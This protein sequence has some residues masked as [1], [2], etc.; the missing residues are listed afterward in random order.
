MQ[1]QTINGSDRRE[2]VRKFSDKWNQED[3][4]NMLA[5]GV[6]VVSNAP[7][8]LEKQRQRFKSLYQ[9]SEGDNLVE[10]AQTHLENSSNILKAS[11]NQY[12]E[13][14]KV[15]K[16]KRSD[17]VFEPKTDDVF[18]EFAAHIQSS[19]ETWKSRKH[20]FGKAHKYAF[21]CCETLSNHSNFF[22]I[23]PTQNQYCALFC[24]V[25]KTLV[26]A[27]ANHIELGKRLDETIAS[28]NDQVKLCRL[29]HSLMQ[30]KDISAL[31]M[32]LYTQVFKL[33]N[34]ILRHFTSKLTRIFNAFNENS[35]TIKFGDQVREITNT[36]DRIRKRAELG[37]RAEIRDMNLAMRYSLPQVD[38]KLDT[39]DQKLD[40]I[41]VKLDSTTKE[42]KEMIGA[43]QRAGLNMVAAALLQLGRT[44]QKFLIQSD[45]SERQALQT[46]EFNWDGLDDQHNALTTLLML[47]TPASPNDVSRSLT[48]DSQPREEVQIAQ[49]AI[50]QPHLFTA[51]N[52]RENAQHIQSIIFRNPLPL[53][54]CFTPKNS[55]ILPE[56]AVMTALQSWTL[57]EGPYVLWICGLDGDKQRASFTKLAEVVMK[58]AQEFE[59]G[60]LYFSCDPFAEE[61][62]EGASDKEKNQQ[63]L[64]DLVN[65]FVWQLVLTIPEGLKFSGNFSIDRFKSCGNDYKALAATVE[66]LRDLLDISPQ[67]S[68]IVVDGVE[69]LSHPSIEHDVRYILE[70]L[71]LHC[72]ELGDTPE[73]RNG[74]SQ[75]RGRGPEKGTRLLLTTTD[76][77]QA[78]IDLYEQN[79]LGMTQI[80]VSWKS[81]HQHGLDVDLFEG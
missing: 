68:I 26:K 45:I 57:G 42:L 18:T 9:E 78:L 54:G 73:L 80:P 23:I 48:I 47:P 75:G 16:N 22:S 38:Q 43:Q 30:T 53:S 52:I 5:L 12:L 39:V 28:V 1:D 32:Q 74:D 79:E 24:G 49:Q 81:W 14:N 55:S 60:A 40:S 2:L 29:D 15:E 34:L 36:T 3:P 4:H 13:E 76:P 37:S 31:I 25:L 6:A 19:V 67:I 77:S 66:L 21:T 33:L 70:L 10:T 64:L 7:D 69:N 51:S 17:Y 50:Q 63:C 59:V 62:R 61:Y 71:V 56:P 65:V 11:W 44:G 35:F 46:I 72:E 58:N 20:T 27:G 8:D 41:D